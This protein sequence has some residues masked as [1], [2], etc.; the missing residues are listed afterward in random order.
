MMFD[1]KWVRGARDLLRKRMTE[2]PDDIIYDDAPAQED[3]T[4]AEA[5]PLDLADWEKDV[6]M[7]SL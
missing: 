6:V 3:W 2:P 1:Q 5:R 4:A 7:Y